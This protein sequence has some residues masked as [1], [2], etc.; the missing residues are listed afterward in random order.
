M[1]VFLMTL[2]TASSEVGGVRLEL[3]VGNLKE[4]INLNVLQDVLKD[5]LPH[6]S[7]NLN[8][9]DDCHSVGGGIAPR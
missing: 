2:L 3:L 9:S 6:C 7:S 1:N 5:I 4:V 8:S